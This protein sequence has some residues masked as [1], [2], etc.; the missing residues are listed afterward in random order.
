MKRAVGKKREVGKFDMKLE[1]IGLNL[2]N[3]TEV[4]KFSIN[5]ER[6]NEVGK[7]LLK[8]ENSLEI[9]KLN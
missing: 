4:E 6:T 5:L 9:G 1:K 3:R 7:Q 2:E 8:L